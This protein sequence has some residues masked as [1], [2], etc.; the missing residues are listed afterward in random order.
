VTEPP[1]G[2]VWKV[3]RPI[4]YSEQLQVSGGLA[5][6]LFAGFALTTVAHLVIGSNHPWLYEWA[7]AALAASAALFVY[8][9]QL[10]ALAVGLSATPSERLDY[11][12]QAA[13]V[14]ER[15]RHVRERQ[16]IEMRRRK[17]LTSRAGLCYDLGML[18]FLAGL[19]LVI[20]PRSWHHWPVG[21][22]VALAVL[23]AAFVIE[24]IWALSGG[25]RPHWLLPPESTE[26]LPPLRDD[27]RQYLFPNSEAEE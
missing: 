17:E 9:V 11:Y 26:P 13:A 14:P 22:F 27:G 3:E 8:T 24:V 18:T 5:A 20:V 19:A 4:N 1:S 15:L 7:I 21:R 25:T 16:W 2:Q 6:P 23:G 10:S 12:P